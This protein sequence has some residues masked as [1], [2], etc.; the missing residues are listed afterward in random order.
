M[1]ELQEVP[2]WLWGCLAVAL[3]LQGTLLF[4]NAQKRGR[5]KVAWFWGLWGL[6]GIPTPLICYLLFVVYF[7]WRK[8]NR[9]P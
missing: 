8:A 3:L 2:Y 6:T 7:D 4:R 1:N 9:K 5:G